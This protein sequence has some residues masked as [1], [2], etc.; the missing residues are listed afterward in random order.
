MFACNKY[1]KLIH[2]ITLYVHACFS[3]GYHLRF[4]V[5]FLVGK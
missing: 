2:K 1:K 3:L 5:S 4:K